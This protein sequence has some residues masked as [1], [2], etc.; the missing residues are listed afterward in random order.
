[1]PI[2]VKICGINSV[3]SA[4]A[5]VRAGADYVGLVF[6]AR[7]PRA[8]NPE[9]ARSLSERLRGRVRIVALLADADDVAIAVA[10]ADAKPDFLQLH[11][12]E[13]VERVSEIRGRTGAAIIKVISV[14]EADDISA[15]A[16]YEGIADMLMFD[17]KAPANATR[18]GGHG[19]AF[20]WQLLRGRTF[21]RPWFL[22]GGLNAENVARAAAISGASG[23]DVSSGVEIA[24]GVKSPDL[25]RSFI[26]NAHK[27]Q[28]ASVTP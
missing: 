18:E 5:A 25:I 6:H 3:E 23:V 2:Q 13:S 10:M 21:S 1:M 17:T 14:A 11:G 7:S 27:A 19:V 20:D 28:F 4:D 24:P 9:Q 22:A 16:K 15:A 12:G 26:D 8:L